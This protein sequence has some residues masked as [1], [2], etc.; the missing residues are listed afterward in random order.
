MFAGPCV[1]CKSETAQFVDEWTVENFKYRE[2]H[3]I[4]ARFEEPP[5]ERKSSSKIYL[6]TEYLNKN[7][8]GLD[9]VPGFKHACVWMGEI[10]S[11]VSWSTDDC[12]F[13]WDDSVMKAGGIFIDKEKA[14]EH[15]QRR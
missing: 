6:M 10:G 5:E 4:R 11:V 8:T 12:A 9:F 15:T 13:Q 14:E 7:H 1:W 2:E 3:W